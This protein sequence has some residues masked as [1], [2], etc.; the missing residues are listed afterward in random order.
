MAGIVV[1]D[2]DGEDVGRL[3]G[4]AEGLGGGGG[5]ASSMA[6][7]TEA[8]DGIVAGFVAVAGDVDEAAESGAP[9]ASVRAWPDFITTTTTA[10]TT[11]SPAAPANSVAREVKA[12]RTRLRLPPNTPPHRAH[13]ARVPVL[14]ASTPHSAP[15]AGHCS[16][17]MLF[18]E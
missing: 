1:A 11:A 3:T 10:A 5:G 9:C 2:G 4:N 16:R 12:L 18:L 15:H 6:A 14:A 13:R 17:L 8:G 7:S